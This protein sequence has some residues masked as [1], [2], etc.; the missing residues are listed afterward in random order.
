MKITNKKY[1]NLY[2]A[3]ENDRGDNFSIDFLFSSL[4]GIFFASSYYEN[5]I[6]TVLVFYFIRFLYYFG[7]EVSLGRT[8]G[9]YQTQTI[10]VNRNGEK[11]KLSMLI[12]RNLS[13][14]ISIISGVSD[15]ERAVHDSLSNTFVIKNTALKKI[16]IKRPLLFIIKELI[17][18][19]LS[20][21]LYIYRLK[22]MIFD[23]NYFGFTSIL[24]FILA[25]LFIYQIILYF[26]DS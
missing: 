12:I 10:V 19:F 3:D 16:E 20:F 22:Q 23:G 5:L 13:R 11:P 6:T 17:I 26:K 1:P 25:L 8:P 9:K 14:F 24:L 21:L 2:L 15:E 18:S 4:I 7:F